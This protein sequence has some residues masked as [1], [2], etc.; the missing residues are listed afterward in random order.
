[1]KNDFLS[2]YLGD[3]GIVKEIARVYKNNKTIIDPH[4][5]CG[6]FA[7]EQARENN[8]IETVP[9]DQSLFHLNA[10]NWVD[11]DVPLILY[12]VRECEG[13]EFSGFYCFYGKD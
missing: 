3:E 10:Y 12:D 6:T 4:S 11:I 8:E 13:K 7:A 9:Y 2:Y 1:M 5:A